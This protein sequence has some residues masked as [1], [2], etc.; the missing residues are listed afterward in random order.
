M[1]LW[2]SLSLLAAIGCGGAGKPAADEPDAVDAGAEAASDAAGG[3]DGGAAKGPP[4]SYT[5]AEAQANVAAFTQHVSKTLAATVGAR[6]TG[7]GWAQE[8][9]NC[10][11]ATQDG[12]ELGL[13]TALLTPEQQ[14][15]LERQDVPDAVDPNAPPD[16]A[17]AVL[18]GAAPAPVPAAGGTP[19]P[20]PL[21][22]LG[23]PRGA[24]G[25]PAGGEAAAPGTPGATADKPAGG[26]SP[27]P[28]VTAGK[29][30]AA[31]P[32]PAAPA[33]AHR[34][35]PPKEL[36]QLRLAGET[37]LAPD[38]AEQRLMSRCRVIRVLASFKLC[39]DDSGALSLVEQ[40]RSSRLPGYD[41][42]LLA[43][44]HTWR[45]RPYLFEGKATEVCSAVTFIYAVK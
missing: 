13:C 9:I 17:C 18:T 38:P 42:K 15:A 27:A 21:P 19:K 34:T 44:I 7:D 45:Y 39:L 32:G 14:R 43:A 28:G 30:P 33:I 26:T 16:P 20:V 35:I 24:A 37:Q 31:S 22:T 2:C 36:E 6:C 40:L 29:P 41:G 1:K 11:A 8:V 4:R 25:K 3:G 12:P 23:L 10:F 5:C